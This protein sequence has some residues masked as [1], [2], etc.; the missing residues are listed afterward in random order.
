MIID[1]H[2]HLTRNSKNIP[3]V[4]YT[5]D[6]LLKD[7][8]ENGVDVAVVCPNVNPYETKIDNVQSEND[9]IAECVKKNPQR[10]IGFG[11]ASPSAGVEMGAKEVERCIK[12]LG[13][14]G[15]ILTRTSL[16]PAGY[17]VSH[18]AKI[19]EKCVELDVPVLMNASRP[20]WNG[21]DIAYIAYQF[22]NTTI[23]MGNMGGN[24]WQSFSALEVASQIANII[25]GLSDHYQ[26][27]FALTRAIRVLG[28]DRVVWGSREPYNSQA[29]SL[30]E[31]QQTMQSRW[32]MPL[33]VITDEEFNAVA[34]GTI[35][36]MLKL[37]KMEE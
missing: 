22:P 32:S 18:L 25:F 26:N 29:A 27:P 33:Q 8:N 5:P 11:L 17:H 23:I 35:G 12:Q 9:W 15:I 10:L 24:N 4:H 21:D 36:R 7:M 3:F 20:G 28:V 14:K 13:M 37:K 19:F 31:L 34:G 2:V 30:K 6:K 1:A 16:L